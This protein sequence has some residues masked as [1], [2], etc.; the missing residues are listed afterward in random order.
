[1]LG[2]S[3][4]LIVL[5]LRL[6]FFALVGGFLGYDLQADYVCVDMRLDF[7]LWT[8]ATCRLPSKLDKFEPW[9]THLFGSTI[10]VLCLKDISLSDDLCGP[11]G[12]HSTHHMEVVMVLIIT[13]RRNSR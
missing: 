2:F 13:N 5:K 7:A 6:L 1:M 9:F 12:S 4:Q 10:P 8:L 3:K 11:I